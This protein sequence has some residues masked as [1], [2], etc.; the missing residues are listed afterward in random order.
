MV[1]F[2][3]IIKSGY[4]LTPMIKSRLKSVILKNQTWL[5]IFEKVKVR[6]RSGFWEQIKQITAGRALKFSC[7]IKDIELNNSPEG[8]LHRQT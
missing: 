4:N 7:K 5:H 6:I 2:Y 8:T 3:L 1:K